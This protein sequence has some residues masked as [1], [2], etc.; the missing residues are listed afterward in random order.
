M[1]QRFFMY[2]ET[3]YQ[4]NPIKNENFP[5]RP[6]FEGNIEKDHTRKIPVNSD[7]H[8]PVESDKNAFEDF[9]MKKRPPKEHFCENW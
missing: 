5:H 1:C 6:Q 3:K 2:S 4:L 8:W 7:R 9:S